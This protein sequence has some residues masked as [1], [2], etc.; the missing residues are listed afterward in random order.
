[1]WILYYLI[2][3]ALWTFLWL[4]I[5]SLCQPQHEGWEN[6]FIFIAIAALPWIWLLTPFAMVRGIPAEDTINS[7]GPH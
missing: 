3:S 1:M 6:G 2:G 7:L 4:G 5:H